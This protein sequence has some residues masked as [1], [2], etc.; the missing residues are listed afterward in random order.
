MINFCTCCI[1]FFFGEI[2]FASYELLIIVLE[3]ISVLSR[4]TYLGFVLASNGNHLKNDEVQVS[5]FD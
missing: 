3:L 2:E 1:F 5:Y 4:I